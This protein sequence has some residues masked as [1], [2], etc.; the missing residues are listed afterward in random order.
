M[1]RASK[2]ADSKYGKYICTDL[3][4]GVV[5]PGYK[6]PQTIGQG[7]LDGFRRP[8]EH[9]IWMDSE[10]I[11][12]A[13]Y[14]EVTWMWPPDMKGQR[15]RIITPEQ[16]KKMP[17]I[18]P[19]SHE[20]AEVLTMFGT[21]VEDPSDLGGEIEFWLEDEKFM[22]TRSFLAYIPAGMRH[23]PLKMHKMYAPM[24]HYTT[25]PGQIYV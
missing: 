20:F 10:V 14:A 25:G 17:G 1:G 6:G 22:L 9:V 21:N 23:C 3:K 5:M 18:L 12:G 13:F 7:Y 4:Q 15:P 2:L 8:M 16:A 11:P 19:H 24:F